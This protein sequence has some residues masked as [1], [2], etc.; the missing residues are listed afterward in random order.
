V[1]D[2]E[3]LHSDPDARFDAEVHI[4]AGDVE[5]MVT[6]GNNPD[7]AVAISARAPDPAE[8][9]DAAAATRIAEQLAYMGLTANQRLEGL[10]VD[11][12]F[13]G[14]C[15]NGR[16]DDLRAAA[17]ILRGRR[18][19]IPGLVVSGSMQVRR[20]AEREGLHRVFVDAGLVWGEPG[21]SA[22]T[23]M[24][25]DRVPAGER[26]AA[27][28]NRNFVGRQGPGSRTHL[29]SPAMAAAAAL[30]GCL[31]DIRGLRI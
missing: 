25:G 23:G 6:W 2:W 19:A 30:S 3:L 13:I 29:M 16:I 22:C 4:D 11:R 31:T 26:C 21:C 28:S 9:K 8:A 20:Q 27:T 7:T 14:T 17:E 5:P 18:A 12:V 15:T 1:Q 24:N 10:P